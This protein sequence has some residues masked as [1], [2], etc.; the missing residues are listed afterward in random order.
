M[1]IAS[2][3]DSP[4]LW[5]GEGRGKRGGGGEDEMKQQVVFPDSPLLKRGRG[6]GRMGKGRGRMG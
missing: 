2:F 4:L 1:G 3:P 6:R 5:R